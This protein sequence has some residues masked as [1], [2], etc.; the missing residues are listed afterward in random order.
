MTFALAVLPLAV[1]TVIV[2]VPFFRPLTT[3]LALTVAMAGSELFQVRVVYAP[4]GS[5]LIA[6]ASFS[7]LPFFTL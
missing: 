7:F 6:P 3:P 2:T 5:S 1:V 4:E